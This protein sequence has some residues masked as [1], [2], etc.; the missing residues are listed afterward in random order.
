MLK[1]TDL[2]LA[3]FLKAKK[4]SLQISKENKKFDFIFEDATEADSLDFYNNS[5]VGSLDYKNAIR[6]LKSIVSSSN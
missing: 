4:F 3:A 1:T 5:Y 6:D 2:Y